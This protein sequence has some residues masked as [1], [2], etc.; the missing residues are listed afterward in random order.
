MYE[1]RL[2]S[3]ATIR[4]RRLEAGLTQVQLAERLGVTST[5]VSRWETRGPSPGR[6]RWQQLAEELGGH[7]ADYA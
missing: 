2:A 5:T 4:K 6:R 7:P 1:G 3:G